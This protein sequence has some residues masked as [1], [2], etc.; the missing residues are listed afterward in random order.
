MTPTGA[1]IAAAVGREKLPASC[2]IVKTG[3]GAGKNFDHANVLRAMLLETNERRM[4]TR[5]GCWR[6]M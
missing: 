2:R 4:T 5:P 3:M 6:P 1:A